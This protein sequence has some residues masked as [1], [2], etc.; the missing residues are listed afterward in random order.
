VAGVVAVDVDTLYRTD[1]AVGLETALPA[2]A[3]A[4]GDADT[5]PAELL[6]L[7]PRPIALG[8]AP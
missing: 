3:P 1:A 6:M 5:R 2:F 8:V 7:D 4:A